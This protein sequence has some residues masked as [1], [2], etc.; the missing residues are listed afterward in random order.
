[1]QRSRTGWAA[2]DPRS[3]LRPRL[4]MAPIT[5]RAVRSATMDGTR[6][7]ATLAR[8]LTA[9]RIACAT[10][11]RPTICSS[12]SLRVQ[13]SATC[14]SGASVHAVLD[15]ESSVSPPFLREEPGAGAKL[16][17]SRSIFDLR[18]PNNLRGSAAM[19][20]LPECRECRVRQLEATRENSCRSLPSHLAREAIRSR[21]APAS[22]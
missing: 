19:S 12:S 16:G 5:R 21:T 14:G 3:Q 7:V 1:M 4:D 9:A 11:R 18:V 6:K 10:L 17:S 8:E 13:I 2:A 15:A 20:A 22:K